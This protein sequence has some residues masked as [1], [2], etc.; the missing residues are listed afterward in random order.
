[1][2]NYLTKSFSYCINQNV[3]D[4]NALK[5]ALKNIVPHAFGGTTLGVVT[6]KILQPINTQ[7]C[8]MV[9]IVLETHSKDFN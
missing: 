9:E 3:G 7:I 8:H 5:K 2:I 6:N 1:M 4:S